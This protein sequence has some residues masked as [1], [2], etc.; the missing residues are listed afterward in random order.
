[1]KIANCFSA[2]LH[3][4]RNVPQGVSLYT[5]L[6]LAQLSNVTTWITKCML[7]NHRPM[8]FWLHEIQITSKTSSVIVSTKSSIGSTETTLKLNASK[9]EL[10]IIGGVIFACLF[11]SIRC[12]QYVA[13]RFLMCQTLDCM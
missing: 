13:R 6:Y 3:T 1:M 2:T 12:A 4:S 8:L 10:V 7:I 11:E 5:L 9:S